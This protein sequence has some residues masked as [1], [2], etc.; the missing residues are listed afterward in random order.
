MVNQ[1]GISQKNQQG[2]GLQ[3]RSTG[4]TAPR[5]D[6][7]ER[8]NDQNRGRHERNESQQEERNNNYSVTSGI[9]S[10]NLIN[11]DRACHLS[12]RQNDQFNRRERVRSPLRV[13]TRNRND[14]CPTLPST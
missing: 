9:S 13:N 6:L 5:V 2:V 11:K 8:S 4:G 12:H 7:Q 10:E 1:G 14:N 3:S